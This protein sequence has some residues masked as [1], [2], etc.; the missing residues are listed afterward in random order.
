VIDE[1]ERRVPGA[2]LRPFVAWAIGYRQAGVGPQRHRGLP[3]P[4]LTFIVT[5]DD[6]LVIEAHVDPR[7]PAAAYDTL[8]GG[9]H[10]SPALITHDG[11]QSGIQ[12][13]LT[14]LGARRLAGLPAG[15]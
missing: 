7:Q 12:L 5:L 15:N 11:R 9:L 14:P 2:E 6:P 8:L 4:W 1:H 10:T 13:G 3:S